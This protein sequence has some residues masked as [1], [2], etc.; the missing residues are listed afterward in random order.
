MISKFFSAKQPKTDEGDKETK[1]TD[2]NIPVDLKEE[3][4]VEGYEGAIFSDSIKKIEE[5]DG[6]KDIVKAEPF[7]ENSS[8]VASHLKPVKNEVDEGTVGLIKEIGESNAS[9]LAESDNL[10][11][12]RISK[13]EPE[14]Q[15]HH[16]STTG[17]EL[18]QLEL[19]HE[20]VQEKP[21]NENQKT[22][23]TCPT[24]KE[25][26]SDFSENSG[27]KRDYEVFSAQEKPRKHSERLQDVKT[28]GKHVKK[29][30]KGKSNIKKS[31]ETQ[32]TL[33]FFF[34]EK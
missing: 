3:P 5:L 27:T 10:D 12:P 34:D 4:T 28:S 16:R 13:E 11:L 2:A 25:G 7:T 29:Q 14:T 19:Q 31:K 32:S 8:A 9:I 26:G 33:H 22:V 18:N 24:M 23:L 17:E 30:G 15:G 6:E 1:S 21:G 20:A